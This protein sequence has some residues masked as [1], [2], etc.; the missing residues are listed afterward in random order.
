LD[1]AS[2]SEKKEKS[3]DCEHALRSNIGELLFW[4]EQAKGMTIGLKKEKIYVLNYKK[5]K[6]QNF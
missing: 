6:Y 5:F 1:N 3:C 2:I 4:A